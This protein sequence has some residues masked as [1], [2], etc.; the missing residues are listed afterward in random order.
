MLA[1]SYTLYAFK[2]TEG[3]IKL[4]KN[5]LRLKFAKIFARLKWPISVELTLTVT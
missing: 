5:N 2:I 1:N 3:F 4:L